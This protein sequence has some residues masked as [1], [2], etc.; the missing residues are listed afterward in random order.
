MGVKPNASFIIIPVTISGL[1][2]H[3]NDLKVSQ[4]EKMSF[5]NRIYYI[6]SGKIL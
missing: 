3:D 4:T 2:D 5:S 1:Y 6:H